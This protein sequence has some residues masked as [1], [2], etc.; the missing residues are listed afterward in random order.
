MVSF[1]LCNLTLSPGVAW[2]ARHMLLVSVTLDLKLLSDNLLAQAPQV[3]GRLGVIGMRLQWLLDDIAVA[4]E[5]AGL[6]FD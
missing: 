5:S 2:A 3:L 4:Q 6:G 1:D